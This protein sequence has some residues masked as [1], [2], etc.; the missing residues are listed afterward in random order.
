MPARP[1]PAQLVHIPASAAGATLSKAQK[2][3]NRLTKRV[4]KLEKELTEFR[5]ATE[6]LNRRIQT[7]Y[8]PLQKEHNEHR[9]TLVELLDENYRRPG[10]HLTAAERRQIASLLSE[11]FFDLL[12]SGFDHLKPILDAYTPGGTDQVNAEAD[13]ITADFMRQMFEMQ[14][15]ITFDP[16]VDISSPAKFEAYAQQLLS[17]QEAVWEAEEEKKAAR[18]AKQKKTAKQLAAEQR[19][20]EEEKATTQSVRTIYRDLV[21]ALHPDR[22]PDPAE[23]ARKTELLQRVTAAYERNELL[24]LLRLQLELE[25]LD[26]AHLENLADT[27]LAPYNRLLREQV[28]ELEQTL[29]SEQMEVGGFSNSITAPTA[30]GLLYKFQR[31]RNE[32]QRKVTLL[33]S[34]LAA[35]REGGTALKQ[36]LKRVA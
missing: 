28:Q 30:H 14:Y 33:A 17:E 5:A 8:Y 7:E 11:A 10:K 4:T 12:E 16:T 34:D 26:P 2:E 9:A 22:E 20:A 27:Q 35:I 3:F 13:Q 21:K 1:K 6:E 31:D 23:K 15:G 19:K 25:R 29:F 18:R 36:F 24:T 32:L